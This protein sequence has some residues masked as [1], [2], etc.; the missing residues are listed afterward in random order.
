MPS[1]APGRDE[2]L[3]HFELFID[4]VPDPFGS[5]SPAQDE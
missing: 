2:K 3:K 1:F 4:A 5:V